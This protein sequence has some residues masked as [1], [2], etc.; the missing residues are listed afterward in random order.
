MITVADLAAA[1]KTPGAIMIEATIP[2][3]V[4]FQGD[5]LPPHCG[6]QAAT[7]QLGTAKGLGA[8]PYAYQNTGTAQQIVIVA[9]GAVTTISFSS[10]GTNYTVLGVLAGQFVLR[11]ND[12]LKIVY[13]VAPT[14]TVY[15]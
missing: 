8:S 10:D 13:V 4:Y 6:P 3:K 11:P 2:P 5:V 1:Q 7:P 12:Y 14:V 9:L 15:S